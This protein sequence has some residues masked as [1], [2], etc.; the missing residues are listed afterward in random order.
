MKEKDRMREDEKKDYERSLHE[1]Q[2]KIREREQRITALL[3]RI[4]ESG[5][6]NTGEL[7][8]LHESFHKIEVEK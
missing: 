2:D 1:L 3:D 6:V 8:D 5:D 4:K 7:K